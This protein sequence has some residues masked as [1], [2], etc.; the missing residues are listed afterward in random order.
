MKK[1]P[2][3]GEDVRPRIEPKKLYYHADGT[4]RDTYIGFAIL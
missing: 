3:S 2:F 1:S 4:G